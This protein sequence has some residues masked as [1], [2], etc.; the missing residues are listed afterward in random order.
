MCLSFDTAPCLIHSFDSFFIRIEQNKAGRL[1]GIC[2]MDH[3]MD[4]LK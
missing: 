2:G 3:G 1:P 4:E